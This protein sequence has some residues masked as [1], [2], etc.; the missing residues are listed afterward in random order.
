MTGAPKRGALPFA[1][2]SIV[3]ALLLAIPA[4]RYRIDRVTC[5]AWPALPSTVR[6]QLAFVAAVALLGVGWAGMVRR[7]PARLGRVMLLAAAV[8]AAAIVPPPFL[9]QDPLYYAALGHA[10]HAPYQPI[11]SVLGADHPLVRALPTEWRLGSSAYF[12]G[13][14]AVAWAIAKVAG[15]DVA[16][17]LRLFQLVGAL[18]MLAS[19]WLVGR[20][21]GGAGGARAAAMVAF[22]PL[23]IIEGTTSAHNDGWLALAA[24]LFVLL[25]RRGRP[26]LG[27]G[28]LVAGVA[29]KLSAIVPAAYS[30]LAE[31]IAAARARLPTR[32]RRAIALGA[33]GVAVVAAGLVAAPH[34]RKLTN[35]L[36]SP[37]DTVDQCTSRAVDCCVRFGLRWLWRAHTAAFAVNVAFR[38]GGVAFLLWAALR[39][40]RPGRLL[41]T[42]PLFV[43]V[44]HLVFAGYSQ[45]WYFLPLAVLVPF[46]EG[47]H[48]RALASLL[49]TE[50]AWY[51]MHLLF[52]CTEV[53]PLPAWVEGTAG[54][55]QMGIVN[56]PPLVYLRR[57]RRRTE[58]PWG[59]LAPTAPATDDG[60]ARA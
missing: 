14:H 36:G 46:A 44:F 43:G 39:G 6:E 40:S 28:A 55:L 48:A 52:S 51:P 2:L 7:A 58:P 19:A 22:S 16:L 18:T 29:F 30:C 27:A 20:A 59:S 47:A 31:F 56:L 33:V 4:A 41:S 57:D 3:G 24:A 54:V 15:T 34:L 45:P 26:R 60:A 9:S 21:V 49:I 25:A 35:V 53:P 38:T 1:A 17:H 12:P 32:R 50:V 42:A 10:A 8:H 37:S 11:V 5:D 13:F 23:A